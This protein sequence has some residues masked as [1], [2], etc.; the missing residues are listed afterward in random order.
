MEE[1]DDFVLDVTKMAGLCPYVMQD[2]TRKKPTTNK[3]Y[4]QTKTSSVIF[5]ILIQ[6]LVIGNIPKTN[7]RFSSLR[8]KLCAQQRGV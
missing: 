3:L 4:F 7:D 8:W 6:N 2:N 1:R 5:E